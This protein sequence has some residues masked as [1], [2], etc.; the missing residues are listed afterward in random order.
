MS[1]AS[2]A[3]RNRRYVIRAQNTH[4]VDAAHAGPACVLR[5]QSSLH[6]A[7]PNEYT[8]IKARRLR[9]LHVESALLTAPRSTRTAL[10][11]CIHLQ[12]PAL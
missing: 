9:E 2:S 1:G 7:L 8:N 6:L 12:Q 4:A 10:T 3:L 5:L 11:T